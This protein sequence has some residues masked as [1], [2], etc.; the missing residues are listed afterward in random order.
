MRLD[1]YLGEC[2]L[3]TRKE[4]KKLIKAKKI[5]VNGIVA[6]SPDMQIDEVSGVVAIEGKVLTYEKYRYFL[7]NKPSGCVTAV[8]DE[9]HP[10]VME[11]LEGENLK[12]LAPVGRLDIDT[13]GLLLITNDGALAHRLLSPAN[14]IEKTYYAELDR[15]CPK[16]AIEWFKQGIDIGDDSPTLP[17][18]LVITDDSKNVRLT[19]VEGRF[20]QV[21]RMFKSLGCKV[22]YLRRERFGP[23]ELS[24]LLPGEYKKLDGAEIL[25][26]DY[27]KQS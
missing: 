23:F 2:A 12:S 26:M 3:G 16:N 13:E 4:I 11:Y 7:L 8:S 19:I 6:S 20:H 9:D 5:T 10:T 14:R 24:G 1:R 18:K 22:L 27:E 17:A 15:P 21:K 25:G